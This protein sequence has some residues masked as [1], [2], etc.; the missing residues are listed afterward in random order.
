MEESIKRLQGDLA[1]LSEAKEMQ[2]KRVNDRLQAMRAEITSLAEQANKP[3]PAH[4]TP[5]QIKSVEARMEKIEEHILA[6][7]RKR[8]EDSER[9]SRKLEEALESISKMVAAMAVKPSPPPPAPHKDD[10]VDPTPATKSDGGE[11]GFEH[12][13]KPG[14][15]F[16]KIAKWYRSKGVKVTGEQIAKANPTVKPGGLI[17]GKKLWVP[18]QLPAVA[19]DGSG[20]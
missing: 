9:L 13:I 4:A 17:V 15:N 6:V 10:Q 1:T 12:T 11:M 7:D 20:K 3:R 2:D 18:G 5:E 19:P 16:E 8:V 14:D